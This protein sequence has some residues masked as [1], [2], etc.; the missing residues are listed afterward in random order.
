M[1]FL[2]SFVA[3]K[4]PKPNPKSRPLIYYST[5]LHSIPI[6]SSLHI[7]KSKNPNMKKKTFTDSIISIAYFD[8]LTNKVPVHTQKYV[9]LLK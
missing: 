1:L 5:L 4:T 6:H 2:F 8:E 9:V 3:T 7:L